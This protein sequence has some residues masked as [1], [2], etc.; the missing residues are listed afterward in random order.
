MNSKSKGN[1]YEREICSLLSLWWTQEDETPSDHVFWRTASSGGRATQRTKR[2]KV[3]KNHYGDVLATDPIGQPFLD[4]VCLDVKKGYA[5]FTVH[6]LVDTPHE[7]TSQEYGKW[8]AKVIEDGKGAGVPHWMLISKRDRREALVFLPRGLWIALAIHRTP[9]LWV[10]LPSI[11]GV[12]A[13]KLKE[14]LEAVHPRDFMRI[15]KS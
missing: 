6:D 3:T 7:I 11:G 8:F 14:F 15:R 10:N 12:C 1:A 9:P 5:K 2:G 13:M 4:V